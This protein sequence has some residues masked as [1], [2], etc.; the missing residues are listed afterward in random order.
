[1][2]YSVDATSVAVHQRIP[3]V[4]L[5]LAIWA[6]VLEIKMRWLWFPRRKPTLLKNEYRPINLSSLLKNVYFHDAESA[7]DISAINIV[8]TLDITEMALLS[9]H[10][11]SRTDRFTLH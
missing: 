4:S 10:E 1:M 9:R 8:T 11:I 6:L 2:S 3:N 7:L 5:D